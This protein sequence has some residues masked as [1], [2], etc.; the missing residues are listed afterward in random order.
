MDIKIKLVWILILI[1]LVLVLWVNKVHGYD[2]PPEATQIMR[3]WQT[4]ATQAAT[5][6]VPCGQI[7]ETTNSWW[8]NL[9]KGVFK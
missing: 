6:Q 4:E 7:Q 2:L 3:Q 1:L 9:W 8:T 5:P